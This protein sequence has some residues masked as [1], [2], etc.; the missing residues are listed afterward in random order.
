MTS[1]IPGNVSPQMPPALPPKKTKLKQS[2]PTQS[3]AKP[4]LSP[5]PVGIVNPVS[6]S[7]SAPSTPLS[8]TLSALSGRASISPAP[9]FQFDP[10][11]SV[12]EDSLLLNVEQDDSWQQQS[13]NKPGKFPL[14]DLDV[15]QRTDASSSPGSRET[16]PPNE[17]EV[18][19]IKLFPNS[20]CNVLM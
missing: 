13:P 12:I 7:P 4:P 16:D 5:K 9:K 11:C 10:P 8:R 3:P 20:F 19:I 2:T 1:T 15:E 6:N 18:R 14:D 17:I